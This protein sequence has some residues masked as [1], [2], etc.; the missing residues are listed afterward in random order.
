MM[1]IF[2]I[3][4]MGC[5]KTTLGKKLAARLGY[6]LVDIDHEIER[7]TGATVA[8]Y[9][10]ANGEDVFR[11]LERDTVQKHPYQPNTVVSTGGGSPCYF[12]NME[13]MNAN[14]ITVY[15]KLSPVA[16]AKRLAK[17]MAKR[18][19]LQGLSPEGVVNFIEN[20]LEE[21]E[22]FYSKA[23]LTISGINLNADTLYA[24]ILSQS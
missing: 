17:G 3:G 19:L 7:I 2:L 11:A 10:A 13:W 22:P 16:L 14:G 4:F 9:F 20:K 6:E 24:A 23:Q 21:R 8:E 18:P 1:K 5:G 15:I 12:D